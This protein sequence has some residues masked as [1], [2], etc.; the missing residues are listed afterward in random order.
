MN[1]Y[2]VQQPADDVQKGN[3]LFDIKMQRSAAAKPAVAVGNLT[4][5]TKRCAFERRRAPVQARDGEKY[6]Q[7]AV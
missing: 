1:I 7:L 5:P 6:I 2:S 3:K 4:Q